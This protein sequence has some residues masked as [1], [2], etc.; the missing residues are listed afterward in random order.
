MK[1]SE[2]YKWDYYNGSV[3]GKKCAQGCGE[4][5]CGAVVAFKA[6]PARL[7]HIHCALNFALNF[8]NEMRGE[9]IKIRV[10]TARRRAVA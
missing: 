9:T 1:S 8:D 5:L 2:Y 6:D 7:F 4:T 3:F 10:P